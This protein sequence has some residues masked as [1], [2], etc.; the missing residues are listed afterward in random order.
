MLIKRKSSVA[1][2]RTPH[3]GYEALQR[4][5][6]KTRAMAG[7]VFLQ[8]FFGEVQPCMWEEVRIVHPLS[9]LNV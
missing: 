8:R 5:P 1:S 3:R 7:P 6:K 4:L 2:S 9:L